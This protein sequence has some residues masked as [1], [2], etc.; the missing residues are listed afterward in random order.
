LDSADYLAPATILLSDRDLIASPLVESVRGRDARSPIPIWIELIAG[1]LERTHLCII[2]DFAARGGRERRAEACAILTAL[3]RRR[4][5][6]PNEYLKRLRFIWSMP[7]AAILPDVDFLVC[8]PSSAL[9]QGCRVGLKPIQIGQ[10]LIESDG[11]SNLFA[12]DDSLLEALVNGTISGRLRLAEYREFE[13][14]CDK[15]VEA[16]A[17]RTAPDQS[18]IASAARFA[19]TRRDKFLKELVNHIREH[20]NLMSPLQIALGTLANPLAALRLLT[21]DRRKR[22]RYASPLVDSETAAGVGS[23]LRREGP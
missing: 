13:Q 20:G 9:L 11:F 1:L 15:L 19:A 23:A 12:E 5:P 2:V 10:A 21:S 18:K 7:L 3:E 8:S 17:S 16:A 14:Y 6:F 22:T 4:Y